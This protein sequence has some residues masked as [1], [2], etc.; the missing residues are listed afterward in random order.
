VGAGGIVADVQHLGR[1]PLVDQ[2]GGEIVLLG[3]R[4]ETAGADHLDP[5]RIDGPGQLRHHAGRFRKIDASLYRWS[6]MKAAWA[7]Q[8][9]A[10]TLRGAGKDFPT[11]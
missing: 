5:I 6:S 9:F 10:P 4:L 2:R 1:A 3:G 11:T 8:F 7:M